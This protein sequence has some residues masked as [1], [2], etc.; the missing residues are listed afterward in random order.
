MMNRTEKSLNMAL[1]LVLFFTIIALAM[2]ILA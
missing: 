1:T 2:D